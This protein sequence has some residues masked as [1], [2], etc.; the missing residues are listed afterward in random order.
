MRRKA[1][2][3][4][5]RVMLEAAGTFLLVLVGAGS[6]VIDKVSGGAL[7]IGG[8]ALVFGGVVALVVWTLAGRSGAHINPAVTL[9]FSSIHQ[10]PRREVVPYISGQCTG[11]TLAGFTLLAVFGPEARAAATLP[12]LPA[13]E[14]LLLEFVLS[15]ILMFT[16]GFAALVFRAPILVAGVLIGLAVAVGAYLGGPDT[17]AAMNPA[18]AFGPALAAGAWEGHWIYWLGPVGGM[19]AASGIVNLVL[20][21]AAKDHRDEVGQLASAVRA[22]EPHRSDAVTGEHARD[23]AR[24]SALCAAFC[25]RFGND[26]QMKACAES[27]RA[28]AARC[29]AVA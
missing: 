2:G 12:H 4:C 23:C 14:S 16:I 19:I 13:A 18:R 10:F 25:D 20:R 6:A 27:S 28:C 15:F 8:V 9:A 11:A 22:P 29:E 24:S 7:G 21:E 1:P 3:L 5:S 26:A 17:G